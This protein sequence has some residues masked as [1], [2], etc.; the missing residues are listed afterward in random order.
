MQMVPICYIFA[1]DAISFL[2]DTCRRLCSFSFNQR[3]V[4]AL[5][6]M[7]LEEICNSSSSI[8]AQR[9]RHTANL[10]DR[11]IEEVCGWC[12]RAV[13]CRIAYWSANELI[14]HHSLS[15]KIW[16]YLHAM[17]DEAFSVIL[18]W[19]GMRCR[20]IENGLFEVWIDEHHIEIDRDA[21]VGM[22]LL[23]ALSAIAELPT[24]FV[25]PRD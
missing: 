3:N 8:L 15:K 5:P 14:T 11:E 9:L 1:I 23:I 25:V 6:I 22:T 19:D 21:V 24:A 7:T 4:V 16:P 18:G 20:R 13:A 17:D 12:R 2:A 10:T